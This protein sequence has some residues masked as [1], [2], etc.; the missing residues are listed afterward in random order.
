MSY[1]SYHWVTFAVTGSVLSLTSVN[2]PY[3]SCTANSPPAIYS[4]NS[5]AYFQL[6]RCSAIY[7][8]IPNELLHPI[9]PFLNLHTLSLPLT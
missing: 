2:S 6:L 4:H 3:Y 8:D 5:K 1:L 7:Y 9:S